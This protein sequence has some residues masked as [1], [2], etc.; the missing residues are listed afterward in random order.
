MRDLNNSELR[1]V[2]YYLFQNVNVVN[3]WIQDGTTCYVTWKID[4]T[5][6]ERIWAEGTAGI[7][8]VHERLLD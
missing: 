2:R 5:E 6:A 1:A 4:P 7:R 3:V 8:V